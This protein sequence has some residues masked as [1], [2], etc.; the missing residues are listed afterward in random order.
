MYYIYKIWPHPEYNRLGMHTTHS[1]EQYWCMVQFDGS[2][3]LNA[4]VIQ[5]KAGLEKNI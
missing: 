2:V 3:L 1:I 5:S 4:L